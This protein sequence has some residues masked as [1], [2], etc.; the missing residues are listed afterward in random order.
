MYFH[1]VEVATLGNALAAELFASGYAAARYANVVADSDRETVE[2]VLSHRAC[3]FKEQPELMKEAVCQVSHSMKPATESRAAQHLWHQSGLFHESTARFK[4]AAEVKG[5][6]QSSGYHFS[7]GKLTA[8][9]IL[10]ANSFKQV[11]GDTVERDNI[12]EHDPLLFSIG[13][14]LEGIFYDSKSLAKCSTS[15]LD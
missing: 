10:M 9:V 14:E 7:I 8:A 4:I 6:G 5:R 1:P 3:L 15:N 12:V 13:V 11:V 2:Q